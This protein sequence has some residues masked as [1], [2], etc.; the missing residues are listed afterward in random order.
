MT[1]ERLS[2]RVAIV[3]GGGS[4]IGLATT[5]RFVQEGA[6]VMVADLDGARL[7]SVKENLGASVDIRTCDVRLEPDVRGV[8]EAT[9]ESFGG[10]DIVFANAGIGALAPIVDA[11]VAEWMRVIEVNLLGPMLAI[12]HAAPRMG[13]GGS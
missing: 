10:I 8:V 9:V 3:T 13:D 5:R 7:A 12:K 11:D 4:G 1:G 6:K 2:G